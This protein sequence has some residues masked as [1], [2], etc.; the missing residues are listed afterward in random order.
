MPHHQ[1]ITLQAKLVLVET[2][3]VHTGI[4]N[5]SVNQTQLFCVWNQILKARRE[6]LFLFVSQSPLMWSLG[7]SGAIFSTYWMQSMFDPN[8]LFLFVALGIASLY[9]VGN[10][11]TMLNFHNCQSGIFHFMDKLVLARNI[12]LKCPPCKCTL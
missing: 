2:T 11:C 4:L 10:V 6:P 8:F 1:Y 9:Y 5:I 12:L 3:L 7:P